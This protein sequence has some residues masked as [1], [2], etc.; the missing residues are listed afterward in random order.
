MQFCFEMDQ[1][2]WKKAFATFC[3][4]CVVRLFC[5]DWKVLKMSEKDIVNFLAENNDEQIETSFLE[6]EQRRSLQVTELQNGN[7]DE[8]NATTDFLCI[9]C[10]GIL[11]TPFL[12]DCSQ[13]V[14]E[15]VANDNYTFNRFQCFYFL[16]HQ[17]FVSDKVSQDTAKQLFGANAVENEAHDVKEIFKILMEPL[18]TAKLKVPRSID[19]N[20]EIAINI[21]H[22][23]AEKKVLPVMKSKSPRSFTHGKGKHPA[24]RL[25]PL[26][27][28]SIAQVKHAISKISVEELREMS[29]SLSQPCKVEAIQLNH[30][31]VYVGGRYNKYSRTLPQTPWIIDGK[32]K[33]ENSV[34][35]FLG[36]PIKDAFRADGYNFSSSGRE[37]VDVR[38]LGT[39][40]P[41]LIELINPRFPSVPQ[42]KILEIEKKINEQTSDISSSGLQIVSKTDCK[43]LKEGEEEKTKSYYALCRFIH[44]P[45]QTQLEKL[46]QLKDLTDVEIKQTTPVRVLHRRPLAV[47]IRTIHKISLR[48]FDDNKQFFKLELSTQA[49]TYIK[50]FVHSDFGRTSPSLRDF[51]DADVDI[52]ELDVQSVD[53]VWPPGFK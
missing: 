22:R 39:G 44:P 28:V 25:K 38:M 16:P 26:D 11:M 41:Y 24:K 5:H 1:E 13:K 17:L 30:S 15:T 12:E 21:S 42:A 8:M 2:T 10:L 37:D 46:G 32:R 36:G 7:G 35:E 47:R 6:I 33:L 45:R 50:E 31:S 29:S 19:A 51:V 53:V 27:G 34:Q 3:P 48:G 9:S 40:R 52:I 49:G 18:V 20:F 23:E 43:R 14:A 4:R